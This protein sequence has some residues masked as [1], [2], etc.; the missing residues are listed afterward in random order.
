MN[1][2]VFLMLGP[3]EGRI[4]PARLMTYRVAIG[5]LYVI[6]AVT[7]TVLN[8][9]QSPILT[10]ITDMEKCFNKLWLQTAINSLHETGL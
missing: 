10:T 9:K 7:N 8:G 1:R 4:S 2:K 5:R 6:G 3:L